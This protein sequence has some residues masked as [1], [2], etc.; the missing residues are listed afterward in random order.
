M[1]FRQTT[2]PTNGRPAT[3]GAS[4]LNTPQK[5]APRKGLYRGGNKWLNL[6]SII[7]LFGIA[8]LVVAMIF[9]FTRGGS[10]KESK[11]INTSKYQ[12]VFLNNGQ[13]YFGNITNL[14]VQ[15]MR[16]TNIYYLTQNSTTDSSGKTTA[17]NYSLVKLG[18]QQIHDPYDEMIINRSQV[19]FW[20]NLQ[21]NGKVVTSIKQF[22]KQNPKG[23]DCSQVS[24]QTQASGSTPTQGSAPSTTPTTAP[25]TTPP[26]TTKK[27]Y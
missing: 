17:G 10:F 5:E 11:Y 24:T 26:A 16:L 1:D 14:N 27:P 6:M 9:A 3:V 25:T 18:C 15:Y 22:I 13:V 8:I 12:A 21:D 19:T 4:P 20:E 7:V 2:Q 23:P